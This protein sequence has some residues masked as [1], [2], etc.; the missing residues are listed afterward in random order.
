M[1]TWHEYLVV[2]GDK[3]EELTKVFRT[4]DTDHSGTLNYEEVTQL[5]SRFFDGRQP[6]LTLTLTPDP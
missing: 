5:A 4:L 1:P 3:V 6:Q 2:S